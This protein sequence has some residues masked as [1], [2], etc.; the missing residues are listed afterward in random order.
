M[1]T[2]HIIWGVFL[3]IIGLVIIAQA[4][5]PPKT[6]SYQGY[7]KDGTGVPVTR[8]TY[9][10]FSLYSSTSGAGAVWGET[11]LVIPVN[12]VYAVNLGEGTPLTLSFNRQYYL[13]V[14]VDVDRELRP[15]QPLTS[16]PY[17]LRTATADSVAPGGVGTE[18][19]APAAVTPPTISTEG[20][21]VGQLLTVTPTGA[22]WQTLTGVGTITGVTAGTGL[23]GGGSS[24]NVTLSI[25]YGGN[26]S[27]GD[28]ARSD[29]NHGGQTWTGS[30][31]SALT[32][33]STGTNA[34]SLQGTANNGPSALGV[35]GTSTSGIGVYGGSTN[36]AGV[37][38]GSSYG[39]GVLGTSG[40]GTGVSGTSASGR[41]VSGTSV[42]GS[43]VVGEA[44][45]A[46][47][48]LGKDLQ[49]GN[50]AELGRGAQAVHAVAFSGDGLFAQS[51]TGKAVLA[52]VTNN[53]FLTGGAVVARSSGDAPAVR[54]EGD[55]VVTG[56][57]FRGNLGPNGGAPFPRPAFDSGWRDTLGNSWRQ[58]YT[59]LSPSTY[60]NDNFVI[61]L[62]GR[63]SGFAGGN[64]PDLSY[65]IWPD[66][67]LIVYFNS[68]YS[69]FRVRIWYIE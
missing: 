31:R 6:I 55:L 35:S 4:A 43:G 50:Y 12:G 48:V 30:W 10:T 37:Q 26:G 52:E 57:K 3:L 29:H 13:G 28:A 45:N 60:N 49:T 16:V 51:A 1:R 39:A 54:C 41:G 21:G 47:G 53:D 63:S 64:G 7:L 27:A 11:R 8:R 62:M 46:V 66:N 9:V 69:Q 42:S 14:Q 65:Y 36:G 44:T 40:V 33:E 17:A 68:N 2:A 56:G 25:N 38:G 24:G 22:A 20:A 19:L 15:L 34:T 18:A 67:S 59:N 58:V 5:S 32:V 23:S 61:D